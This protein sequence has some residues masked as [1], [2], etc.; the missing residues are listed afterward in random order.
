MT[1]KLTIRASIIAVVTMLTL[2]F[3]T[4]INPS[5]A[6][7]T[8][9]SQ[10]Q[11]KVDVLNSHV[12]LSYSAW[13]N[14]YAT[15]RNDNAKQWMDWS[16]DGC[17]A[18]VGGVGFSTIFHMGCLR[19]DHMWRSM[20]VID[21]ATGR[22]WNERN[23]YRADKKFLEDNE[24]TCALKH[25]ME[26]EESLLIL[27]SGVANVFYYSVKNI[28]G[29]RA[30][31]TAEK[32]SV[33]VSTDSAY[34]AGMKVLSVTDCNYLTNADNRCLP[35]NYVERNGNPL[36]PQNLDMVPSGTAIELYAVRANQQSREGPP[37][38]VR[39]PSRQ[40][41]P[42]RKTGDLVLT[43]AIPFIISPYRSLSCSNQSESART[44]YIESDTY[45]VATADASL[46]KKLFYLKACST[47]ATP[48]DPQ[49]E[50]EAVVARRTQSRYYV[51]T[52]SRVR[53]YQNMNVQ[54]PRAS[55]SPRPDGLNLLQAQDTW[56]NPHP[57][58][59]ESLDF[60]EGCRESQRRHP[61]S[62]GHHGVQQQQLL[63]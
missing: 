61:A 34:H 15:L 3:T 50:L 49:M 60:R 20:A 22:V 53:H 23:R 59:G 2:V 63:S 8:T 16:Q 58:N 24:R 36:A 21:Q 10:L 44:L 38:P 43:V 32:S 19:H 48:D 31:T 5:P 14:S 29:N 37:N 4:A 9:T 47:A 62:G 56:C 7:A 27:C 39:P 45:P 55:F 25:P 13:V 12:A 1:L 28:S 26:D 51:T 42:L 46:K 35:I 17:S 6:E 18:P 11:T 52:G 30:A 33:D 57:V 54:R 41:R 40:Q